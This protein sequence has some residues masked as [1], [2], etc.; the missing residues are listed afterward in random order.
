[1]IHY[2]LMQPAR[3]NIKAASSFNHLSY[4]K[5]QDVVAAGITKLAIA[6]R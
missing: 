4:Q 2:L 3:I 5:V 6:D 1:M